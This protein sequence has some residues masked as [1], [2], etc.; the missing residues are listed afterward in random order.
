MPTPL[1][2]TATTDTFRTWYENTN[3]AI[4]FLN[5]SVVGDNTVA[6][7]VFVI[8]ANANTS[9]AVSNN[10]FVN[11]SLITLRANAV[12]AANLTINSSANVVT[13]APGALLIQPINGTIVNS[14]ITLNS[15]AL[16]QGAVSVNST[17]TA[18]GTAT[19]NGAV[20]ITGV[21]TANGVVFARQVAF[22]SANSVL[23]PAALSDPQ[24]NDL[25][26]AGLPDAQVLQLSPSINTVVTGI[27][28]PTNLGA[29]GA[30]I[31]YVQNIGTT[32]T[33][34]LPSANGS[35]AANNQFKTPTDQSVDILPGGAV[36]LLW[37]TTNR[38][39]RPLAILGASQSDLSLTGNLAVSGTLTVA[40]NT[41][42]SGNVAVAN[43]S[44]TV[45]AVDRANQRVGVGTDTPTVRFHVIGGNTILQNT[46]IAGVAGISGVL[47]TTANVSLASAALVLRADTLNAVFGNTINVDSVTQSYVRSLLVTSLSGNGTA[48]FANVIA[49]GNTTL[50]NLAVSGTFT[51]VG[52]TLSANLS[53]VNMAASA[54]V[55]V[56]SYL[57]TLN[58][59]GTGVF[60]FTQFG[61]MAAWTSRSNNTVYQAASDGF[62]I[63]TGD[64]YSPLDGAGL[65][66]VYV[67]AS[68][69]PTTLRAAD[70]YT[71][72][73]A[74]ITVPVRRGEYYKVVHTV[75]AAGA[76]FICNWVSLGTG[77]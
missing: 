54:N 9:L 20:N 58:L 44:V 6:Y 15:T 56:A 61:T 22:T 7:G 60:A 59:V 39:W 49:A 47:T 53:V 76:T 24:Y 1:P 67:D 72:D 3:L 26:Y 13:F 62:V 71:N 11:T 55:S 18:N 48:S 10:F 42:L 38:Q 2:N 68:N 25:T 75:G 57:N 14:A 52:L 16:F 29:T 73:A 28:A 51:G 33:V 12:I 40:G 74:S 27:A 23:A 69:P 30:R 65:L 8:G 35:S 36:A 4:A 32:Y 66:K 34:S 19:V 37:T 43:G 41:T 17:F 70:A 50:A 46:S 77:G 21:T 31:L 45:F 63:V 5:G 64:G